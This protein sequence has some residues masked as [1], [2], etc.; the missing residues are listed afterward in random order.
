MSIRQ[1]HQEVERGLPS[2]AYLLH[3][4][5]D[6]L[7]YEALS[8][9]KERVAHDDAFNF[10]AYDL[11][12]PDDSIPMEQVIDVLNT[13]PF[14]SGRR[15]V[16]IKNIQKLSKPD[17]RK[18][19]GYLANPSATSLLIMLHEGA[20]PKLFD[21]SSLKNVQVIALA[22]PE[23]EI[24]LWI[25]VKAKKKG[26]SLTDRAVEYLISFVGTDLGMLSA[27][28]DKLTCLGAAKT[29]DIDEIRGTVYSGADYNAFDLVDALG[30]GNAGEVFRI[31]ENV[32]G[33]QDP[34]M[35]LGALNYQYS[36]Q[37]SRQGAPVG[38]GSRASGVFRLLHEADA[39]I[40]TSHKFVLEDL[41]V[42]LLGMGGGR[43][44]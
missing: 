8:G 31:F 24:P 41:L 6:F 12:S 16:V 5:E 42:K 27:E 17:T 44:A 35:L 30:Q 25:K 7:L 19:E 28:I 37:Y 14:M 33:N 36:R 21:P 13:L 9:I 4:P 20:S 1:L 15:T 39:A 2:P 43:R 10:E 32:T 23:K 18:L 29:I 3:S 34:Q 40:K 38:K 11:K 26:V 22:V